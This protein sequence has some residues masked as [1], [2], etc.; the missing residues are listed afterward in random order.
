MKKVNEK[1]TS[2]NGLFS[3]E[4]EWILKRINKKKQRKM[5]H[6]DFFFVTFWTNLYEWMTE[7]GLRQI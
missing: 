7:L 3:R 4:V 1:R 5:V 6:Y 2:E